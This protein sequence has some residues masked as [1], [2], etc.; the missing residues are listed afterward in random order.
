MENSWIYRVYISSRSELDSELMTEMEYEE[1]LEEA[2][3][4]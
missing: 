1:Y 2:G 3:R 4:M